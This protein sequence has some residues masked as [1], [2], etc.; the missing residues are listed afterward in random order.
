MRQ[1]QS[2]VAEKH[3]TGYNFNDHIWMQSIPKQ[4]DLLELAERCVRVDGVYYIKQAQLGHWATFANITDAIREAGNTWMGGVLKSSTVID[5]DLIETFFK[6]EAMIN[7][8]K[9]TYKEY[10]GSCP[11]IQHSMVIPFGPQF[12]IYD[13]KKYLNLW[14]DDMIA[15]APQYVRIGKLVLEM[16]YRSLCNGDEINSDIETESQLL[17]EQV[18]TNNY[19]NLD[20]KMVIH[21]LAAIYQQPGI[22]LQTNLWFCGRQQGVGKGTLTDIMGAVLGKSYVGTLNQTEVEAGWNDHLKGKLLI[23]SNEFDT[24]GKMTGKAWNKWIKAH[25]NDTTVP[26]RQRNT[27]AHDVL[28]I[29]NYLFT[30]ND[31]NPIY[32]DKSDR[33]NH[34]IKT[35]DDPYWKEFAGIIKTQYVDRDIEKIAAGFAWILEQVPLDLKFA[36]TSF[37][38]TLKANIIANSQNVVEEWITMDGLLLKNK[39]MSATDA[40]NAYKE[41]SHTSRPGEKQVTEKVFGQ[42]LKNAGSYGVKWKRTNTGVQYTF[43]TAIAAANVDRARVARD[44]SSIVGETVEVLNNDV[45]IVM[46][47]APVLSQLERMREKLRRMEMED[48]F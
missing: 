42:L 44:V 3:Y 5:M 34:L 20:F 13:N 19:T 9:K 26:I 25:C 39:S 45:E 6:G 33:R 27:T 24:D 35:T 29:T 28:N 21:W 37:T 8:G 2:G 40:Y 16:I 4:N 38:N 18:L 48:E 23:N 22:N 12:A 32:L 30:S 11:N 46:P 17:L 7:V 36:N 31:E 15:P 43:G 41:W 1:K 47:T 10:V 14:K